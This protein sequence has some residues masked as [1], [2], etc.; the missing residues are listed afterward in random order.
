MS[1]KRELLA[2]FEQQKEELLNYKAK[3]KDV[4]RAYRGL[5]KE[6]EALEISLTTLTSG[7]IKEKKHEVAES[8]QGDE[9][10]GALIQESANITKKEDNGEENEITIEDLQRKVTTLTVAMTT[11]TTEKKRIEASFQSDKKRLLVDKEQLEISLTQAIESK[12]S[13]EKEAE[14]KM[15]DFRSRLIIGQHE[16]EQDL[17]KSQIMLRELESK[18]A[19]ERSNCENIQGAFEDLKI[20]LQSQQKI[21]SQRPPE[22]YEKKV[23]DLQNELEQVRSRLQRAEMQAAEPPLLKKIQQQMQEMKMQHDEKEHKECVRAANVEESSRNLANAHEDRVVTLEN[24]L[25]ELS[26]TVAEYDRTRNTDLQ[27][28]QRLKDKVS[29][30]AEENKKLASHSNVGTYIN[31]EEEDV[32]KIAEHLGKLKDQLI[33]ANF[34]TSQPIDLESILECSIDS[35]HSRCHKEYDTL[36]EEFENYKLLSKQKSDKS[37]GCNGECSSQL[38]ELR[39]KVRNLTY[40]SHTQAENDKQHIHEIQQELVSL[41]AAHSTQ[42]AREEGDH[43]ATLAAVEQQ[44]AAQQQRSLTTMQERDAEI[45]RLSKKMMELEKRTSQGGLGSLEATAALL[46]HVSGG[47]DGPLLHHLEDLARK[48]KNIIQLRRDKRECET[49]MR[50][51]QMAALMRQQAMQDTIEALQEETERLKRNSSRKGENL[52]YLKNVVLQYMTSSDA[53]SRQLILNAIAAILKFTDSELET[54]KQYNALWW[55]QPHR[56]GSTAHEIK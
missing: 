45:T 14:E 55:W 7:P 44:L 36:K 16:K 37:P 27:A 18:L 29:E 47:S 6:K 54:V 11:L 49:T 20:Q 30:L 50:E 56:R 41:R 19:T 40:A 26:Q 12:L 13:A 21:I 38:E 15:Q 1:S 43:R 17:Q 31:D 2:A 46:S 4:V 33:K 32:N 5:Q 53:D 48:E 39:D 3:F 35:F 23:T 28:Q 51:V 10:N 52:E 24:R 9:E 42:A 8:Q 34:R 22:Q 25:S